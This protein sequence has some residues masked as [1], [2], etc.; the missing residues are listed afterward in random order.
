MAG[1]AGRTPI[2]RRRAGAICRAEAWTKTGRNHRREHG[3]YDAARARVGKAQIRFFATSINIDLRE[4]FLAVSH[5][6]A[7]PHHGVMRCRAEQ[8]AKLPFQRIAFRQCRTDRRVEYSGAGFEH[9]LRLSGFR[10]G[11]L[12]QRRDDP[13]RLRL[14]R[15]PA[16]ILI[17]ALLSWEK[18]FGS[19]TTQ[20]NS[21]IFGVC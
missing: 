6:V 14:W 7:F 12:Y 9:Q 15:P 8:I 2:A 3:T 16:A 1:D 5:C 18:G 11:S 17:A 20:F 10:S 4:Q 21:N 19:S 13:G